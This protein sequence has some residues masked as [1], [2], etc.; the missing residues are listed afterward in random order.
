LTIHF[1]KQSTLIKQ[2]KNK[3]TRSAFLRPL[4]SGILGFTLMLP[5]CYFLLTLLIRIFFGSTTMY[6]EISPSFLQSPFHLF[7]FHKA[8]LIIG[9]LLLAVLFNLAAIFRLR[10][11]QGPRGR[12]IRVAYRRHWLNTA[13]VLQGALFLFALAIYTLIQ[14]IRY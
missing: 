14:H 5:A 10:L 11:V 8:Q 12:E 6:Y 3:M 9:C 4:A 13:I 1:E 2:K 7:A